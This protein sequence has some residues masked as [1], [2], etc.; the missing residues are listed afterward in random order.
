[1]LSSDIR[2]LKASMK[3]HYEF[4]QLS[5]GFFNAFLAKLDALAE[6]AEGME[7]S[8]VAPHARRSCVQLELIKGGQS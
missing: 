1:M 8:S 4:G 5:P 2:N 6:Q 3:A 7:R